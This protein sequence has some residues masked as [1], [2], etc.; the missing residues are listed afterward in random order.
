MKAVTYTAVGFDSGRCREKRCCKAEHYHRTR[1]WDGCEHRQHRVA[2]QLA[3][4]VVVQRV[5]NA[6]GRC[7]NVSQPGSVV[8]Q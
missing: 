1:F 8:S 5:I 3:A 6:C 7:G 4:G 2:L